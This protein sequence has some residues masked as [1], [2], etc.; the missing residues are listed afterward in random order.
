MTE[1]MGVCKNITANLCF[2][3]GVSFRADDRLNAGQVNAEM[4]MRAAQRVA[5][6]GDKEAAA[7]IGALQEACE[8][9]L[10]ELKK[11]VEPL[12]IP[13]AELKHKG[14]YAML[15]YTLTA[16]ARIIGEEQTA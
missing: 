16:L 7:I 12:G 8:F 11:L 10:W 15:Y 3:A 4:A 13:P 5:K 14:G 6:S 2:E 9:A 1:Q